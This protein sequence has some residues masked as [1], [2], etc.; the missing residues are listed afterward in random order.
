MTADETQPNLAPARVDSTDPAGSNR[1]RNFTGNYYRLLGW[2]D[3]ISSAISIGIFYWT[4]HI[5]I[6]FGYVL[7][8][9]LGRALK[10]GRS[11]AR[12]WALTSSIVMMILLAVALI[13]PENAFRLAPWGIN[14]T[15]P[16]FIPLAAIFLAILAVPT[17]LLLGANGRRSFTTNEDGE[18]ASSNR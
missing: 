16:A 8:F 13:L 12:M 4:G 2:I 15:H 11:S 1:L 9:W 10:Q 7:W 14:Q 18:H 5:A 17:V 3:L 6:T